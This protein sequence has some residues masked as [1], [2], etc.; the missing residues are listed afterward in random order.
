MAP[1]ASVQD[2]RNA[3]IRDRGIR[4]TKIPLRRP[5]AQAGAKSAT[6]KASKEGA[7]KSPE[8]QKSA[9]PQQQ[10]EVYSPPQPPAETDAG[11]GVSVQVYFAYDSAMLTDAAKVELDR[12]GQALSSP[13][14]SGDRWFIEGHTDA[15]GSESYNEELSQRRANSV[16]SYLV[17]RYGIQSDA[18]IPVGKGE[19]EPVDP[20]HPLS[21]ANRRV[22][23][24]HLGGG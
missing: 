18:L 9:T 10:A 6:P 4:P 20:A 8:R 17:E 15:A 2:Y 5:S 24:K 14:F 23:V 13:E 3:L 19:S 16:M 7:A 21:S 22:R 1:G 11:G 12:L